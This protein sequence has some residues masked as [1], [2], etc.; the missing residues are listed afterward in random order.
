MNEEIRSARL[1]KALVIV[2]LIIVALVICGFVQ[3]A[4]GEEKASLIAPVGYV[5]PSS[6]VLERA[7]RLLSMGDVAPP[8]AFVREI[9]V[10]AGSRDIRSDRGVVG[11]VVDGRANDALDALRAEME[12]KD[13][14]C[15]PMDGVVGASFSKKGGELSWAMVTCSQVGE[16]TS[17]VV[18]YG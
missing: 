2:A 10:L 17:V 11:Y 9:G 4:S 15:T 13:W 16:A 1:G 8:D 14:V 12:Q 3:G 7:E 6:D 18:R 5:T